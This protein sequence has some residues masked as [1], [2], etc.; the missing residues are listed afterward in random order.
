MDAA[1]GGHAE[2]SSRT[3]VLGDDGRVLEIRRHPVHG[4]C[5]AGGGRGDH[6]RAAGHEQGLLILWIHSELRREIDVAEG[7]PDDARNREHRRRTH[8]PPR[9]L[10]QRKQRTAVDTRPVLG[11]LGLLSLSRGWAGRA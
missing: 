8:Q 10:H 4:G 9:G 6:E 1:F 5:A 2:A 7:R 11:R 3:D